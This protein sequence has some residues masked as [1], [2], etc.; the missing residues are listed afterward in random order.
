MILTLGD[1]DRI[2]Y[3]YRLGWF[4][5]LAIDVHMTAVDRFHC[6]TA[7]LIKPGGP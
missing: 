4:N 2:T 6:Q 5:S 1:L 3:P 7:C